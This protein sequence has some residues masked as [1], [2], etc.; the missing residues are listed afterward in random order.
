MPDRDVV[1]LFELMLESYFQKNALLSHKIN[2]EI[3]QNLAALKV[4][5]DIAT[6]RSD[7]KKTCPSDK[8]L[9]DMLKQLT[10]IM[11]QLRSISDAL[12]TLNIDDIEFTSSLMEIL[13]HYQL[14]NEIIIQSKT[15]TVPAK[16]PLN[17]LIIYLLVDRFLDIVAKN[18]SYIILEKD[19]PEFSKLLLKGQFKEDFIFPQ[20]VSANDQQRLSLLEEWIKLAGGTLSWKVNKQQVQTYLFEIPVLY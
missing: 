3:N 8:L 15:L 10:G 4:Q 17:R 11:N 13:N 5:I 18:S 7:E 20:S 19:S 2:E 14:Q 1:N 6:Q 9:P 16:E 12:Y